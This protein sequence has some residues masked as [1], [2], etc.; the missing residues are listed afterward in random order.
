VTNRAGHGLANICI[1]LMNPVTKLLLDGDTA[2]FGETGRDGRY[3]LSGATPGRYVVQFSDCNLPTRYPSQLYPDQASIARARVV[4]IRAA[5]VTPGIDATIGTGGSIFGVVTGPS[6]RP[7]ANVCVSA[8]DLTSFS[9]GE[10][11]TNKRGEYEVPALATG[12]YRLEVFECLASGPSFGG[13]VKHG[14]AVVAPRTTIVNL[15]PPPGGTLTGT[16]SGR[17]GGGRARLGNICVI[18]L[19]VN[20]RLSAGFGY[21]GPEGHYKLADLTPGRYRVLI[22]D[23]YCVLLNVGGPPFAPQWYNG[24]ATEAT[25]TPVTVTG[26]HTTSSVSVT[27]VP[28]GAITGTVTSQGDGPVKGECVTAVPFRTP[29]DPFTGLTTPE[30]AITSRSGSYA[31]LGLPPGSYKIEFSAGCGDSGF[32]T[33]WWR[34]VSSAGSATPVALRNSV[35]SGVDA[36]LRR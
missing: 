27:L 4:T 8:F 29:A 2:A 9:F 23:Q 5:R 6:R 10:A 36:T 16:V 13:I 12:R 26:G 20:P 24:R 18:A 1:F 25:A 30:I 35:I 15:K 32:A 19:P 11:L 22:G 3:E 21:T 34:G 7:L 31:L 33:Q 17:S 14:V 28:F